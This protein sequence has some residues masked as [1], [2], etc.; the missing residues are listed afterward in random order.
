MG[1][2]FNDSKFASVSTADV[3]TNVNYSNVIGASAAYKRYSGTN[4]DPS[5]TFSLIGH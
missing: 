1:L 4:N 2:V 5:G 3:L